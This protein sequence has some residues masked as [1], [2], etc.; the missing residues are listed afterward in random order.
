MIPPKPDSLVQELL[1]SHDIIIT[2]S[3]NVFPLPIAFTLI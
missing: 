1:A 2:V 3:M